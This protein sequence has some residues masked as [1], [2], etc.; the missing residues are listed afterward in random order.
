MAFG[1]EKFKP[2]HWLIPKAGAVGLEDHGIDLALGFPDGCEAAVDLAVEPDALVHGKFDVVRVHDKKRS[3][4]PLPFHSKIGRFAVVEGADAA[5]EDGEP[6]LFRR[7]QDDLESQLFGEHGKGLIC[8][9]CT[10]ADFPVACQV[11]GGSVSGKL[12]QAV[13]PLTRSEMIRSEMGKKKKCQGE[14]GGKGGQCRQGF[15]FHLFVDGG[16]NPAGRFP[17]ERFRLKGLGNTLLQ[18]AV[19]VQQPATRITGLH[20][21]QGVWLDILSVDVPSGE[22]PLKFFAVHTYL[23]VCFFR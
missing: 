1:W 5:A 4:A 6:Q 20:V 9:L 10:E 2:L 19:P 8:L 22:P 12:A 3:G 7:G 21:G 13:K 17:G 11:A 16:I 14:A 23:A 15:G 18:Q